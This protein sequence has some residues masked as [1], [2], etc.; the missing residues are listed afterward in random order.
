MGGWVG[1]SA[2]VVGR[3]P[4]EGSFGVLAA[5]RTP[6]PDACCKGSSSIRLF[7]EGRVS[8]H[9]LLTLHFNVPPPPPLPPAGYC[10][11]RRRNARSGS[12]GRRRR[13]QSGSGR[14]RRSSGARRRRRRRRRRRSWRRQRR[15]SSGKWRRRRR[16][17]SA[18]GCGGWPPTAARR[19]CRQV[20]SW[21]AVGGQGRRGEG[22][23]VG[24]WQGRGEREEGRGACSACRSRRAVFCSPC[25]ADRRREQ[26][27]SGGAVQRAEPGA[28][29]GGWALCMLSPAPRVLRAGCRG[30]LCMLCV[31]CHALRALRTFHIPPQTLN[32]P[33][34]PRRSSATRSRLP[35]SAARTRRRRWPW[36][37]GARRR[38]TRRPGR[39]S[40]SLRSGW[41]PACGTRPRRRCSR[42]RPSSASGARRRWVGGWAG[43]WVRGWAR[44]G[45]WQ[46]LTLGRQA[47]CPP[48]RTPARP[49][50][51]LPACMLPR[52]STTNQPPRRAAPSPPQVRLLRK[53]LDKFPTGTSKRWEAV[54]SYV[55][56]RTVEEVLDM[57]KHGLKAGG[58]TSQPAPV[59]QRSVGA[60]KACR[61]VWAGWSSTGW[62]RMGGFFCGTGLCLMFVFVDGRL[63]VLGSVRPVLG[64]GDYQPGGSPLRALPALLSY[65]VRP[66]AGARAAAR[67]WHATRPPTARVPPSLASPPAPPHPAGKFAATNAETFVVAKKRQGNLANTAEADS[68]AMA[69]TDVQARRL[70][71]ATKENLVGVWHVSHPAWRRCRRWCG[72]P[73]PG[74]A[75]QTAPARP[76]AANANPQLPS[77]PLTAASG[78]P[79]GRGRAAA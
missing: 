53:A 11:A 59:F 40:A 4:T 72:V 6:L 58:L 76:S 10:G 77:L 31:G 51:H 78:E 12:G 35:P 57:V 28:A 16:R 55:R 45:G 74:A 42:S 19:G 44:T 14:S 24:A 64:G 52:F 38:R 46:E 62:R 15:A 23:S 33:P 34:P 37:W 21:P 25:L 18:R 32:L 39:R 29:A 79:Q 7:F 30:A 60:G 43:G 22:G 75:A 26:R 17:G 8:C 47:A 50:A 48:A 69:F 67:T 2:R 54:Q 73:A 27:S 66:P 68:R 70:C 5:L 36:R 3:P 20:R 65:H 56:T 63:W 13:R 1:H 49:S 41:R 9:L 71:I 61:M